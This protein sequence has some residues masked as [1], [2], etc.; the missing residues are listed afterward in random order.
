[1]RA[2]VVGGKRVKKTKKENARRSIQGSGELQSM[3]PHSIQPAGV[4]GRAVR[5]TF[6]V[7]V[8]PQESRVGHR[9]IITGRR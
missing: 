8:Q 6:P 1:V 9:R 4:H 3:L 5:H 7:L 2:G